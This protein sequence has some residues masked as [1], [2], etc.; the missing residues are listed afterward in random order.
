MPELEVFKALEAEE[1]GGLRTRG[2][3][4]CWFATASLTQVL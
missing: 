4:R 2:L 1:F 3:M